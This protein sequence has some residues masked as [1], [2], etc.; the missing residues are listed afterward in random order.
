MYRQKTFDVSDFD[1]VACTADWSANKDYR[2]IYTIGVVFL[3][4]YL[5]PL[6]FIAIF[7]VLI[8]VR[9]WKRNVRGM[10]GTRAQVNIH[11]VKI[12]IMRMLVAVFVTFAVSWLPLYSIELRTILGPLPGRAEKN[13]LR[14]YLVPMAQWLGASNSCVNPFIYCYFSDN[15]RRSIIAVVHSRSCCSKIA[16]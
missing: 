9:V 10:R 4:C 7:C 5:M 14:T 3:T 15:F 11:R 12:R 6:I 16:T 2:K 13:L 8:A 1:F